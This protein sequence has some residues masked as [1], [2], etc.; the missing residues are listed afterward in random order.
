M[1]W[2][3]LMCGVEYKVLACGGEAD[4]T[5]IEYD[6]RKLVP[7]SA[8]VAVKG[9]AF[10]GHDFVEQAAG[11]GAVMAVVE[12]ELP[13][14]PE[15][16]T[17]LCVE[18]TLT[19]MPMMAINFYDKPS[20]DMTMVGVTGTKGKTT[21]TT[22]IHRIMMAAGH[23]AGLIGTIENK[24]GEETFPAQYT[25]PQAFDLEKLLFR[26][27]NEGVDAVTMEVSSHALAL[28]RVDG[29]KF[30]VAL[31]TN[32]SLDHLDFHHTMEAYLEAKMELFH[33]ARL[34]LTNLDSPEGR[35]VLEA[36]YCRMLGYAIDEESADYRAMNVSMTI[37]GLE[38]DLRMPD[39]KSFHIQYPFPGRFNVYNT[40]AAS[41]CCSESVPR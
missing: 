37:H 23:K 39:G 4:I 24:I 38:Y 5:S 8:F 25:T 11:R 10:D 33:R 40:L 7:G 1:N 22:L 6:S 27:K 35:K 34:G 20:D 30:D 13:S 36:G 31:F 12:H 3:Q 41:A 17:V 2:K 9:T 26:M 19:A 32:L 15:N 28:H 18:S 21:T 16:M 14:Y 29:M